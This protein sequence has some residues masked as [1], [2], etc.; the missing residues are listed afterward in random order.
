MWEDAANSV[1]GGGVSMPSGVSAKK[2]KKEGYDGRTKAGRKF[3]EKILSRR[4]AAEARKE[5]KE[6]S[7]EEFNKLYEAFNKAKELNNLKAMKQLYD[8]ASR[9]KFQVNGRDS[10]ARNDMERALSELDSAIRDYED[11]LSDGVHEGTIAEALSK[12]D[13]RYWRGT[14]LELKNQA[15]GRDIEAAFKKAGY[16]VSGRGG[17]LN[18]MGTTVKFNNQSKHWGT[19]D[20]KLKAA[21]KKV[22]GIDVDKL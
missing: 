14:E 6:V 12:Y 8:K 13:F 20:K 11:E 3:V 18:V 22:L 5:V 9:A 17:D 7:T 4:K 10:D 15:N 1:G 16:N 2:K 19:D 21:I